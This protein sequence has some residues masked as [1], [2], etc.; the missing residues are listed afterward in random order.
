M[1]YWNMMKACNPI[2][3][4]TVTTDSNVTNS[5]DMSIVTTTSLPSKPNSLTVILSVSFGLCLVLTIGSFVLMWVAGD[6]AISKIADADFPVALDRWMRFVDLFGFVG[7]FLTVPLIFLFLL[8]MYSIASNAA[9]SK[10]PRLDSL[11]TAF[12]AILAVA[13][14]PMLLM[15]YDIFSTHDSASVPALHTRMFLYLLSSIFLA[16]LSLMSFARRER[17][18]ILS[19]LALS[20]ETVME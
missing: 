15:S 16:T 4:L 17:R 19:V 20:K 18:R 13:C 12:W 3:E 11:G 5:E 7:A 8:L 1:S 2:E 14:V 9:N 10:V 6:L